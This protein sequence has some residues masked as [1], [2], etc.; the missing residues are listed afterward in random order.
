VENGWLRPQHLPLVAQ[1]SASLGLMVE[2]E[3]RQFKYVTWR[4][5]G[6]TGQVTSAE[7][8]V[9]YTCGSEQTQ[10]AAA[11]SVAKHL[12]VTVNSLRLPKAAVT[13][14]KY[15]YVYPRP[16]NTWRVQIGNA[17]YGEYTR[18][19]EAVDKAAQLMDCET[20]D[21]VKNKDT[22]P[23]VAQQR[24][25]LLEPL[26]KDYLPADLEDAVQRLPAEKGM[27][28]AEPALHLLSLQGKYGPFRQALFE[29]WKSTGPGVQESRSPGDRNSVE[30]RAE[31][32]FQVVCVALKKC[33]RVP[34]DTW[35]RNCGRGVSYVS[36]FLPTLARLKLL[37]HQSTGRHILRLGMRGEPYALQCTGKAKQTAIELLQGYVR[38]ADV[39]AEALQTPLRTC[40]EW[41]NCLTSVRSRLTDVG[42]A[43][44]GDSSAYL[45]PWTFRAWA[46]SIMRANH[47]RSLAGHHQCSNRQ[48]SQMFP[49]QKQLVIRIWQS[50][51]VKA[52]RTKQKPLVSCAELMR[53]LKCRCP[54]E[55]LTCRL[56]LV[57]AGELHALTTLELQAMMPQLRKAMNR[58]REAEGLWPSPA[59]LVSLCRSP[60]VEV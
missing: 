10:L 58:F 39:F 21:L 8:K 4:A 56:C 13:K 59:L 38:A 3:P 16:G 23:K 19:L 43:G 6:W 42:A 34:M 46:I 35:V 36:G 54:V 15:W 44:M 26:Y 29:A 24:M 5:Y 55:L 41:I 49:D 37:K 27:Y 31:L 1:H 45:V 51:R 53:V 9:C 60:D 57:S 12:G 25:E 33:H 20:S 17:H 40:T 2:K 18:Q 14:Q 50:L 22:P 52:C 48:L 30:S 32:V 28:K 7:G 47:V 11:K